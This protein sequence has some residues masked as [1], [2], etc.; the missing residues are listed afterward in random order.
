MRWSGEGAACDFAQMIW[1]KGPEKKR[2]IM[3]D[4]LA[5]SFVY[6]A[7]LAGEDGLTVDDLPEV[8]P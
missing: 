4:E 7:T 6:F 1:T 8:A 2:K 3:Y 5:V